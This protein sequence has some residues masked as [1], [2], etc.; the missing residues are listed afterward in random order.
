MWPLNKTIY[1]NIPLPVN[2]HEQEAIDAQQYHNFGGINEGFTFMTDKGE[3]HVY[4]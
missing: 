2:Q 3:R 1:I 4:T